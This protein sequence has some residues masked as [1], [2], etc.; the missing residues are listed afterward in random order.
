[1]LFKKYS[2][3]PG[4][5]QCVFQFGS[6]YTH[7]FTKS[8]KIS[9]VLKRKDFRVLVDVADTIILERRFCFCNC[10]SRFDIEE[11]MDLT[12]EYADDVIPAKCTCLSANELIQLFVDRSMTFLQTPVFKGIAKRD[13][14]DAV[15]LD[16]SKIDYDVIANTRKAFS[17][18]VIRTLEL[19]AFSMLQP[20]PYLGHEYSTS[21]VSAKD[22]SDDVVSLI[23]NFNSKVLEMEQNL[24]VRQRFEKPNIYLEDHMRARENVDTEFCEKKS[25][26]QSI[27]TMLCP[28]YTAVKC[29]LYLSPFFGF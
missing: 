28:I 25:Y 1:M 4:I 20:I 21:K 6:V 14:D 10:A 3:E 24:L 29:S 26:L 11:E 27:Y 12:G 5:D 13:T 7:E 19:Q 23:I 9:D 8:V 17:N 18:L 22:I 2:V 15:D 16:F